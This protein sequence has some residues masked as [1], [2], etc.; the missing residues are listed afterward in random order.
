D[1]VIYNPGEL[2]VVTYKN[3]H[4]WA[5][6]TVKTAG[7][8]TQLQLIADRSI[9]KADG[10]DLSFITLRMLDNNGLFV[11]QANNPVLFDISGP[12]EIIATD[13]GDPADLVA[14]PSKERKAYNGLALVIIRAKAGVPGQIK[15]TAKSPGLT[16]AQTII[17][18]R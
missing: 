17:N 4:L 14:F 2:H 16:S 1:S 5:T 7:D 10:Q 12:G 9:I 18:T 6:D 13:N 3:G 15:V 8:A 11:P